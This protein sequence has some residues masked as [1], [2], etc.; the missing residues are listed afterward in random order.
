M[1]H[2][3]NTQEKVE[4][5]WELHWR[6]SWRKSWFRTETHPKDVLHFKASILE[7]LN[8]QQ[9]RQWNITDWSFPFWFAVAQRMCRQ[10]KVALF[11]VSSTEARTILSVLRHHPVKNGREKSVKFLIKFHRKWWLLS[12]PTQTNSPFSS[13]MSNKSQR[14]D[15]LWKGSFKN[16]SLDLPVFQQDRLVSWT[17]NHIARILCWN[18]IEELLHCIDVFF[19]AKLLVQLHS[20]LFLCMLL[21]CTRAHEIS[22]RLNCFWNERQSAIHLGILKS[23]KKRKIKNSCKKN[24]RRKKRPQTSGLN[25]FKKMKL[26]SKGSCRLTITL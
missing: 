19:C 23:N 24:L 10:A 7:P 13:R 5:L 26:R 18:S 16:A 25:L 20:E 1:S 9:I 14:K 2:R 3:K 8:I 11:E 12:N 4:L 6:A 15:F 17:A 21:C 22:E